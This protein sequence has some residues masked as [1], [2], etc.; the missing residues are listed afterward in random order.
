MNNNNFEKK[1]I[2][3]NTFNIKVKNLF[4]KSKNLL[5]DYLIK[6]FTAVQI[7]PMVSYVNSTYEISKWLDLESKNI[8]KDKFIYTVNN[9]LQL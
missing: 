2:N 6:K 9:N 4:K 8:Y 3:I 7:W 5:N 1:D